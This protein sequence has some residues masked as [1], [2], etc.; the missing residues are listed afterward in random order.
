MQKSIIRK[1]LVIG[2]IILFLGAGVA[3]GIY[4]KSFDNSQPMNRGWLYVGGTGEGNYTKIQDAIDNATSGDT[5]FVYS[6]IYYEAVDVNKDSIS[7]IGENKNSTIIEGN[8][9]PPDGIEIKENCDYNTISGFTIR[10]FR[11]SGIHIHSETAWSSATCNYNTISDCIIYNCGIDHAA[12]LIQ[13]ERWTCQAN[14]NTIINCEVYNCSTVGLYIWGGGE[15]NEAIYNQYINCSSHDN[16]FGVVFGENSLVNNNILSGCNIYNNTN[17]GVYIYPCSDNILYHNNIINNNQNTYDSGTNTWYN[18]T[19]QE[20]NYYDDYTGEDNNGDG[21]GD[22]PYNIS[23]GSNQDLYPFMYPNGWIPPS[24]VWVDD[25]FNQSTPGWGYDHFDKIQYGIDAVDVGGTVFVY[26]GTY[27]ETG[28]H[29]GEDLQINNSINI[30]GENKETTFIYGD[31]VYPYNIINFFC[32]NGGCEFSNFTVNGLVLNFGHSSDSVIHDVI[33]N[34]D[35]HYDSRCVYINAYSDNN[36]FYDNTFNNAEEAIGI[37]SDGSTNNIF[38]HNNCINNTY[39]P[40]DYSSGNYFYNA[41]LGEGN[42]YDDYTGEDNDGDGIGDTPYNIGGSAGNQDNYPFMEPNGWLKNPPN[43]PSKPSG[44]TNGKAGILYTYTTNTTDP[45]GDQVYYKWDWGDGSYSDWLGPY[46]S[47]IEASASQAWA[48][49]SYNIKVKAKDIHG[50]ESDWSDPLNIKMP[51]NKAINTLFISFLQNFLQS[52]LNIF[53]ILQK[54][55]QKSGI[56]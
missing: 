15:N 40:Y 5:V 55:I 51:K 4:T 31:N 28:F 23:G 27:L 17:F 29:Y 13:A 33:V 24:Y 16:L 48:K 25:D 56:Q 37:W 2:I 42:Y 3:S 35:A 53:P 8:N 44:Q 20:G 39:P 47:G 18:S 34:M 46:N 10:N 19:I 22:T 36:I 43:K 30:M 41:T 9:T 52:H 21:I 54:I 32:Q 12:L 45:D 49:G 11:H 1:G 26:S 6:G 50:A 38:Y 7:L 14:Y